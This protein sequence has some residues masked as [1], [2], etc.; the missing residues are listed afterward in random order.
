MSGGAATYRRGDVA[1]LVGLCL[2]RFLMA[3]VFT[4]YAAV[5]PVLQREW[6]MSAA[7]AGSVA[8]AFQIGYALSLVGFNLLAD[9]IGARPAFLWS[10][11]AGAPTAM[12]FALLANGPVSAAVLYGVTALS[13]GG[14][15]TPGLILI[16]ERFPVATRGRATGFFLAAEARATTGTTIFVDGGIIPLQPRAPSR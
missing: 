12:A 11:I 16:A 4:S 13:M 2:S 14:N 1:W 15:Y 10:S 6:E 7:A 9:R 8:S 5:L 3:L